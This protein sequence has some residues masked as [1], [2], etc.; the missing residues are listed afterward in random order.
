MSA[1]CPSVCMIQHENSWAD[2][3]DVPTYATAVYAI[4]DSDGNASAV[5]PVCVDI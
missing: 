4:I 2:L 3:D 5:V 1:C